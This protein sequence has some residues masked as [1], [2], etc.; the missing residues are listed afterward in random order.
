MNHTMNWINIKNEKPK[1]DT[2]NVLLSLRYMVWDEPEYHV[3]VV[4][5]N[6]KIVVRSLDFLTFQAEGG[7][8]SHDSKWRIMKWAII[9]E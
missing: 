5:N 2:P 7:W 9:E 4:D 1:P 6:G 8:I 3:G